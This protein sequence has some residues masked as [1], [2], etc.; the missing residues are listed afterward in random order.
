M[1]RSHDQAAR[2]IANKMGGEYDPT[3]SPDVRGPRGRVEV[4]SSA[5]EISEALRQLGG[6]PGPAYIALP[7]QEHDA[8]KER[9]KGLRTGLMDYQGN[10]TKR[11]TRKR[12]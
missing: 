4:K 7:K 5:D 1:G 10:V 6:G 8:A 12:R 9:L 3:R 11:S 2:R